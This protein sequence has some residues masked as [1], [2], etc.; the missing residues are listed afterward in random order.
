MSYVNYN[1]ELYRTGFRPYGHTN[2]WSATQLNGISLGQ[3]RPFGPWT[4]H[5]E[6]GQGHPFTESGGWRLHGVIPNY[7]Q[8]SSAQDYVSPPW[9][10]N[11]VPGAGAG[12]Y[13]LYKGVL[14]FVGSSPGEVAL[15][16][17]N[18]TGSLS[19][20]QINQIKADGQGAIVQAAGGD[21][22]LANAQIEE[23]N[24]QLDPATNKPASRIPWWAWGVLVG[25]ILLAARR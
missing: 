9:W 25:G 15:D 20:D 18:V 5:G 10:T 21:T 2:P 13:E 6:L 8:I 23:L 19:Q 14:L 16:F 4:L 12:L 22:T 3:V 7:S 1:H 17:K 24:K 11:I